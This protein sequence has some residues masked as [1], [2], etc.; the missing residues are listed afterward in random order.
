MAGDY[1]T[2]RVIDLRPGPPGQPARALP[3]WRRLIERLPGTREA[4]EAL[5]RLEGEV[6]FDT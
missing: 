2:Q 6:P 1:C 3:E 4:R 5:T